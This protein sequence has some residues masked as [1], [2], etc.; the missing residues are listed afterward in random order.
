MSIKSNSAIE[1]ASLVAENENDDVSIIS[2]RLIFPRQRTIINEPNDRLKRRAESCHDAN[3]T[4]L[5][6]PDIP[7]GYR[8]NSLKVIGKRKGLRYNHNHTV[9]NH[10]RS[11]ARPRSHDKRQEHHHQIEAYTI[12][13]YILASN[14]IALL[15]NIMRLIL[16][17][18]KS[19]NVI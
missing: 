7:T 15:Y 14:S 2:T 13:E 17:P 9:S 12:N 6:S 18:K 4:S 8:H 19:S 3:E 5:E 11:I 1:E 10:E 16:L